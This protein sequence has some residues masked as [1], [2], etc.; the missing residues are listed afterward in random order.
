M[1]SQGEVLWEESLRALE[2]GLAAYQVVGRV[3]AYQ[4]YDG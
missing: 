4:A 1:C 2:E 3:T